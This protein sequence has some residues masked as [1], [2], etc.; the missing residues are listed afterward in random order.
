MCFTGNAFYSFF[1]SQVLTSLSELVPPRKKRWSNAAI[2]CSGLSIWQLIMLK[3]EKPFVSLS[4]D[5]WRSAAQFW[6]VKM[7]ARIMYII[8]ILQSACIVL[9]PIRQ[10]GAASEQKVITEQP[11]QLL[12][13]ELVTQLDSQ[14]GP[15]GFDT[16][17]TFDRRIVSAVGFCVDAV[18][19]ASMDWANSRNF[20]VLKSFIDRQ[21]EPQEVYFQFSAEN[22][23]GIYEV[24]YRVSTDHGRAQGSF[25]FY[26]L[27]GQRGLPD[28]VQYKNFSKDLIKAMQCLK[29]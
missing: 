11:V 29:K 9:F 23:H 24:K 1:Y 10:A 13:V 15:G 27:T 2:V 20:S 16:S 14:I 17:T 8:F 7:N 28:S 18:V 26:D 4:R 19:K 12:D 22:I 21:H 6:R 5:M 3:V 25:W